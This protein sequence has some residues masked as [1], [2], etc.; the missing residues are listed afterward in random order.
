M[1]RY[2]FNIVVGRRKLIADLEGDL[3]AGDRAARR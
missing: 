1:P 2:F 3:L